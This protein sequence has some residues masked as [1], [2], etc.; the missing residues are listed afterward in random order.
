M[1]KKNTITAK[2]FDKLFDDGEDV[3]QYLDSSSRMS[4]AEFLKKH[5]IGVA[6]KRMNLDLP[7]W[8]MDK[9]DNCANALGMPRQAL[10]RVW[11]LEKLGIPLGKV[12]G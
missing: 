12:G 1:K 4:T 2:E 6:P 7:E 5:K 10:I 8:V 9:V 11:I 3:S